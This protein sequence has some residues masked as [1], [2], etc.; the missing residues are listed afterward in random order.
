[1]L[2]LL[3]P[4]LPIRMPDARK[5][6]FRQARCARR[7]AWSS[8]A[9]RSR[10]TLSRGGTPFGKSACRSP[11][12]LTAPSRRAEPPVLRTRAALAP[13]RLAPPPLLALTRLPALAARSVAAADRV[14]DFAVAPITPC[15]RRRC[16]P[17]PAGLRKRLPHSGQTNGDPVAL[18]F[19]AVR[20]LLEAVLAAP[21]FLAAVFAAVRLGLGILMSPFPTPASITT[22]RFR[23]ADRGDDTNRG[24]RSGQTNQSDPMRLDARGGHRSHHSP[25]FCSSRNRS[26]ST[27]PRGQSL[28]S[29]HSDTAL[30]EARTR[31]TFASAKNRVRPVRYVPSLG[32]PSRLG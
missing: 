21:V 18:F 11:S 32:E 16:E 7:S 8:Q 25:R 2:A 20:A 22:I 26:S 19:A 12:R 17:S 27:G 31:A 6:S 5:F 24:D 23:V 4:D 28:S 3:V 1:M 30:Y 14:R 10:I 15:V 29:P 13:L 9:F